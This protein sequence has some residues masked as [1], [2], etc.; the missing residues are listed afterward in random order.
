MRS[1]SPRSRT[2]SVLGTIIGL[3]AC[4]G[5]F[6]ASVYLF[7]T[8]SSALAEQRRK[9]P[10]PTVDAANVVDA[11]RQTATLMGVN[12]AAGSLPAGQA[13][14]EAM[15]EAKNG[16]YTLSVHA[17][18][19]AID[20]QTEAYE[21][22]LLRRRP[23]AFTRIGEMTTDEAGVFVLDWSST[24]GTLDVGSYP[25]VV[26]TREAKDG[27]LDPGTHVLTGTFE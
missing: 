5:L 13:G 12:G 3:L 25:T 1:R 2:G 10:T 18:P 21:V 4:A 23:F 9:E 8:R 7:R 17:Q 24:D 11:P 19:P 14:G 20:R 22:W 6:A 16:A 26:V 27:N 15:R